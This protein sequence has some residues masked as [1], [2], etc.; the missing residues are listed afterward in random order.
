MYIITSF[1]ALCVDL[2]DFGIEKLTPEHAAMDILDDVRHDLFE[3][4]TDVYCDAVAGTDYYLYE[5]YEA[6]RFV[7][8]GIEPE[9]LL[10]EVN[11]WNKNILAGIGPALHNARVINKNGQFSPAEI[12]M[13]TL[14]TYEL[15]IAIR[16]LD[17]DWFPLAHHGVYLENEFGFPGF[18]VQ[19][20]DKV[21]TAIIAQPEKYLI[22][23]VMP[24]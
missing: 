22:I 18:A 13:D 20:A 6:D 24:K 9:V 17:N 1:E 11:S 3:A 8:G 10:N 4:I 21:H 19:V 7:F 23:N 12:Q 2:N 14:A 15:K 16:E 5:N